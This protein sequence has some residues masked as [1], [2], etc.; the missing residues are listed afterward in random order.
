MK[1]L[2]ALSLFAEDSNITSVISNATTNVTN[3]HWQDYLIKT[4]VTFSIWSC[5]FLGH[6]EP[7][8]QCSVMHALPRLAR[9]K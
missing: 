2:T 4:L 1:P 5:E 7:E 9:T 6:L 8:L 3:G